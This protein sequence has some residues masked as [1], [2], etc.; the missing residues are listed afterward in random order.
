MNRGRCQRCRAVVVWAADPDGHR[1]PIDPLP[2]WDGNVMLAPDGSRCCILPRAEA[3][4]ILVDGSRPLHLHHRVTCG[5][6][7]TAE[8]TGAAVKVRRGK[9]AA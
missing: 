3:D 8:A 2:S 6:E 5:K 1:H 4:E 7:A 9:E